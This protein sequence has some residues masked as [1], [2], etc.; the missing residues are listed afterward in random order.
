MNTYFSKM[1]FTFPQ[2]RYLVGIQMAIDS[3]LLFLFFLLAW[4]LHASQ[5][6]GSIDYDINAIH[7][8]LI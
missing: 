4:A 2:S 1:E 3:L 7:A 6:F 5:F 8:N